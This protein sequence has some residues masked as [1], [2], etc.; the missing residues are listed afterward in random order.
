MKFSG[1]AAILFLLSLFLISVSFGGEDKGDAKDNDGVPS[2]SVPADP[3]PRSGSAPDTAASQPSHAST[4]PA[5]KPAPASKSQA[6]ESEEVHKWDPMPAL[7]GNPGLFTLETGEILPKGGFDIAF[8]MNKISRMPGSVTILQAVPSFGVGIT[9]WL[10]FFMDWQLHD[11]VHVD[12]GTQLSL[13]PSTIGNPQYP[14][15]PPANN[16]IY[17]SLLPGQGVAPGFVEDFPFIA[18]KA[19]GYGEMDMGFK[20]GLLSEKKGHFASLSLRNDFYIPTRAGLGPLLT[21]EVQYGNFNYGIGLEASKHILHRSILA[22]INWSYRFTRD[23]SFTVVVNGTPQTQ[24][25]DLSDQMNVGFG[26][27][28]FPDKRFNIITEY[29]GLIYIRK[30]IQNTSFGARDPVDNVTGIRIYLGRHVALDAGYRYAMNLSNDLDRNGFIVKVAGANWPEKARP[31]DT[32]TSSCSVDKSS[33]LEGSNDLVQATATATDAWGYPLTYTWTATGG[34]ISGSGPYVRWDS[35]GVGP[36]TYA[37]T[38]H[39]DNG[40]GKTSTCSTNVTVQPKPNVAPTMSCSA[41]RPTVYAGERDQI[42]AIVKDPSGT[43]LNYK[44]QSNGG[45]IIGTGSSVQLDT[46]GLS[47][48]TYTVTGRVENGAGGAADCSAPVNVQAPPPPP[49]ASKINECL[50]ARGSAVVNNVCKRVLDDLAV[51]LQAE[52]KA[53]A[54]FVGFAEPKEHAAS[55]LA[56]ERAENARKYL[57]QKKSVDTSRVELR[58]AVGPESEGKRNRRLDVVWIPDGATY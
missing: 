49:Q 41:E 45:Q 16:T 50:F 55:K 44:W 19:G 29:N 13:N 20:V 33:V 36:G 28:I 46:S 38:A 31:P 17:R 54:A 12:N 27:L 56:A 23:Q 11:H 10:S 1:R 26:M 7:D 35:T 58:S 37:L 48:G 15:S 24:V 53:K 30:G 2:A 21:N 32:L 51:R 52:P 43:A 8:S 47:P 3:A 6:A 42:S 39:V 5:P 4:T 9:R 25:L 40:A 22:T 18:T 57:G 14:N 34:Q